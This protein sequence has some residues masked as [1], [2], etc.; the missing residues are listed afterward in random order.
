MLISLAFP[1][2]VGAAEKYEPL[3][4]IHADKLEQFY[5]FDVP[6]KRLTW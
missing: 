5:R 2:L 6:I 1:N 3:R 4:L